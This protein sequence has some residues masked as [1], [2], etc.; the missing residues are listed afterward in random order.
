VIARAPGKLV[1]S[2]AYSV[3]E[4]APAIVAAV[5]R[6]V[7]ADGDRPAPMITEEVAA[8][9][10]A[11]DLDRAPWFDASP[12]RAA[13][14]DGTSRKLGLGSSAAILVAS[15]AARARKVRGGKAG[16]DEALATAVF[17]RAFAAHRAAQPRGSG[18]DVAASAFGGVV[19]AQ[20]EGAGLRVDRHALPEGTVIEVFACPLSSSTAGLLERV[21]LLAERD[22]SRYRRIL[23]A[24][25]AEAR[26]AAGAREV[27]ELIEAIGAQFEIFVEL[28]NAAGAEIVT[29]ETTELRPLAEAE[30][31][32][33]GPSGAGGGDIAIWVGARPSS[34]AFR[35]EA[36][37]RR[38]ERLELRIGAPGVHRVSAG[39]SK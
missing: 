27:K 9:I 12:L 8:A 3:L 15:L 4:G 36:E 22:G 30:G 2:G 7:I 10:A 39:E 26:A 33:F 37:A 20:I 18:I 24:A 5:D 23:D 28:G 35:R 21:R 34:E 11:G 13:L 14:A 31:A 1:L 6:Y 17:P 25:G 29:L 16:G 38:F 19:R 32:A